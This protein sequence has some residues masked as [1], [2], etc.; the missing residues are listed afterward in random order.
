MPRPFGNY[1]ETIIPKGKEE[2]PTIIGGYATHSAGELASWLGMT[3]FLLAVLGMLLFTLVLL[4]SFQLAHWL[5][6]IADNLR[7]SA[8]TAIQGSTEWVQQSV[9]KTQGDIDALKSKVDDLNKQ[10]DA[11]KQEVR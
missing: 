9:Q 11:L 10:I 2:K 6:P 1:F 4:I 7:Q 5:N 8:D 3:F